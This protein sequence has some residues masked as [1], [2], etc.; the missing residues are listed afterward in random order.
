MIQRRTIQALGIVGEDNP[1]QPEV[2]HHFFQVAKIGRRHEPRQKIQRTGG[3]GRLRES[4][5]SGAH[6]R[7]EAFHVGARIAWRGHGHQMGQIAGCRSGS[8]FLPEFIN[9]HR[10]VI[11]D[12]FGETGG[13]NADDLGLIFLDDILDTLLQIRAAAVNGMLFP[14]R[15]RSDVDGFAKVADDIAPHVGGAPLGAMEKRDGAFDALKGQGRSQRCA[16]LARIGRGDIRPWRFGGF[17][18]IFDECVHDRFP[19]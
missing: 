17:G 16:Q 10:D 5:H 18:C 11:A 3:G 6:S 2:A 1:G 12:G 7:M 9:D 14:E 13:G 19:V 4:V 15:R 8:A